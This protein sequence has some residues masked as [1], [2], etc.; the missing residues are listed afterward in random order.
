M[1]DT[2]VLAEQEVATINVQAIV[3]DVEMVADDTS[4]AERRPQ[5]MNR[6]LPARYRDIL[7]QPPPPPTAVQPPPP[8]NMT[9]QL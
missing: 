8:P 1:S 4:L 7:P 6:R 2:P 5:R 3:H 9:A